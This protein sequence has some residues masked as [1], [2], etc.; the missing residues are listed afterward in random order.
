MFNLPVEIQT[1]IKKKLKPDEI[2][3]W[4]E[5]PIPEKLMRKAKNTGCLASLVSIPVVAFSVFWTADADGYKIPDFSKGT[6]ESFSPLFGLIFGI[7]GLCQP[8]LRSRAAKKKALST[9]YVI[10]NLRVFSFD[11]LRSEI[12]QSFSPQQFITIERHEELD[13]SGDIIFAEETY[14]DSEG[15]D[16]IKE[17]GFLGV[18]NVRQVELLLQNFAHSFA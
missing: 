11:T 12:Y 15:V 14:K 18:A 8:L 1:Q 7:W 10:S 16:R 3:V 5:Q 9:V 4:T 6:F 17:V 13:G 2:I